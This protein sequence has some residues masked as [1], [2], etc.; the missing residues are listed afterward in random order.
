MIGMDAA[1]VDILDGKARVDVP[2]RGFFPGYYPT[3]VR[4]YKLLGI[5]FTKR[6]HTVIF[7][8]MSEKTLHTTPLFSYTNVLRSFLG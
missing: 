8:R 7:C 2:M 1:S 6:N 5:E 4:L 3:L